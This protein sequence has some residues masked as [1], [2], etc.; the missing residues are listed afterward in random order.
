MQG[1]FKSVRFANEVNTIEE[2]F[3][4]DSI[5][6]VMFFVFILSC[7]PYHYGV[8]YGVAPSLSWS[9]S[10]CNPK[11]YIRG[12]DLEPPPPDNYCLLSNVNTS[13]D[14]LADSYLLPPKGKSLGSHMVGRKYS[15][16]PYTSST[17]GVDHR[18]LGAPKIKC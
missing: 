6:Q 4:I 13:N 10:I 7:C 1:P 11:T 2:E 12:S 3:L 5:I 16:H 15:A 8:N 18:W 9:I 14:K 17:I